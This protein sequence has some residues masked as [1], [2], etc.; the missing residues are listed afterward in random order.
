MLGT[1]IVLKPTGNFDGYAL[2]ALGAGC[3]FAV[4]LVITRRTSTQSEPIM[5]LV[6]QCLLGTLLL[7]PPAFFVAEMP[8]YELVPLLIGLGIFSLLGHFL[9]IVAFQKAEASTLAPLVYVELIGAAAI[10]YLVFSDK[11]T[12]AF[13]PKAIL[14]TLN[15]KTI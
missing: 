9:T 15:M 3:L 11:R 14:M 1:V 5:S 4:Y 10:G 13:G 12:S 6:F 2:L 8:T 7:S